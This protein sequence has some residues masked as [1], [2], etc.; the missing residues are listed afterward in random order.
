MTG[1]ATAPTLR[2]QARRPSPLLA[3]AKA[4]TRL[5]LR[6]P[7]TVLLGVLLPTAVLAGLG[8][9]PALREPADVFGGLRFVEYFAPSLLAISIAVLGLQNLP[10][11]LATYREKGI[12]R[13]L[14]A[15]P[16]RPSAVL[17]VQLLLNLVTAAAGTVL[18]VV[19]AVVLFDVPAP[20]HPLGFVIAFVCGTAAV[21]ALGLL[22]AALTPR[23]RVATGVG[24][25]VFMVTQFFAGVYLPKFLLPDVIVRIGEFVPPGIGAFQGAWTG[26]GADPMQLAVMALIALAATAVAARFFRWE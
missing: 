15:T 23:A 13:R 3:L 10:T 20:R 9:I 21:F 12:L 1:L 19:V 8:A 6:D 18:M 4:E 2:R 17:V 5:F 26:E 11:A 22:V 25:V 7:L 24:S 14:S 16:V